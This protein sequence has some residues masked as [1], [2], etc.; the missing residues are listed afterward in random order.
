M[1]RR[2]EES[3]SD[4]VKEEIEKLM[5]SVRCPACKGARLKPESL[6]VTIAHLNIAKL[7]AL[8]VDRALEF[9]E[10]LKLTSREEQIA[11]QI[12]KELRARLGFLINVGLEYLTLDSSATT[13]S[14][15]PPLAFSTWAS[16]SRADRLPGSFAISAL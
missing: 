6:A 8:P 12:V 7:T 11:R 13:L 5:T 15:L 9:F 4:Y 3:S 1:Q 16:A 10:A 14:M 2:Y